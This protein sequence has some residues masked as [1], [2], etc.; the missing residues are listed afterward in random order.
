M[1][2]RQL[3]E[4]LV[5]LELVYANSFFLSIFGLPFADCNSGYAGKRCVTGSEWG[6]AERKV[7]RKLIRNG[8]SSPYASADKQLALRY[9]DR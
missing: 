5:Q 4:L 8:A 6:R 3:K 2:F 9:A 1:S 7:G